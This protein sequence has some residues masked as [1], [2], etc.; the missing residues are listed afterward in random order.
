[1]AAVKNNAGGTL[2]TNDAVLLWEH[3]VKKRFV[4]LQNWKQLL[5]NDEEIW[6]SVIKTFKFG[7]IIVPI[8]LFSALFLAI[9]LNSKHLFAANVFRTLF[10]MPIMIPVVAA[11]LL[12][13]GVLDENT[14]WFNVILQNV[15]GMKA[16]GG[17]GIR[18]LH[19]PDLIYYTYTMI[20]I[21][22]IGNTMLIFLAGLQQVPTELYEASYVD[23][24]GWWRRLFH[25]TLPMISPVFFYNLVVGL[26]VLIQYFLVPYILVNPNAGAAAYPGYPDG[27]TNFMMVYFY[28][29]SFSF[30]KMG[31]GA[32]IA[33]VMFVIA[34]VITVTM[35]GTAKYWVYYAGEKK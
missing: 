27:K 24:A 6:P 28:L 31:Y 19:N 3:A 26:I 13:R 1:M 14:G 5:F 17:E 2:A 8:S 16:L 29:Q 4:G 25:I 21:W 33:W 23:G 9:M 7:I 20:G 32:A 30:F 34:L 35:F 18:W 12:W 10:Y 11:V 15:F 22:A